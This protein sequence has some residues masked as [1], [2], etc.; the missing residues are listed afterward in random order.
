MRK[1]ISTVQEATFSKSMVNKKILNDIMYYLR[2]LI[3]LA[4]QAQRVSLMEGSDVDNS[5]LNELS[6]IERE[7]ENIES[8]LN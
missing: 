2:R 7:I 1:T 3:K 6:D 5:I 4:R 8:S